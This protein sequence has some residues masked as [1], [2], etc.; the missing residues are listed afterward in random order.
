MEDDFDQ[1]SYRIAHV[2]VQHGNQHES[3]GGDLNVDGSARSQLGGHQAKDCPG[4][5]NQRPFRG[6]IPLSKGDIL[7]PPR[8]V[9]T[10]AASGT[11]NS[12]SG[13][14]SR[15]TE[16]GFELVKPSKKGSSGGNAHQ[17]LPRTSNPFAQLAEME[18]SEEEGEIRGYGSKSQLGGISSPREVRAKDEVTPV[19][20]SGGESPKSPKIQDSQEQDEIAE[21]EEEEPMTPKA[22]RH[23]KGRN[24]EDVNHTPDRGNAAK[25]RVRSEAKPEYQ[26][27]ATFSQL[28]P[29]NSEDPLEERRPD[30]L[31][32]PLNKK[33]EPPEQQEDGTTTEDRAGEIRHEQASRPPPEPGEAA[34]NG[35]ELEES[36]LREDPSEENKNLFDEAL[37]LARKREQI[38][39]RICR[40]RSRIR[41][42]NEGDSPSK[43]FF[44]SFKAKQAYETISAIRLETG[45][46]L[47]DER[48]I[49]EHVEDTYK[50]LYTAEPEREEFNRK[51]EEA[52]TL[53][54]KKLTLAQNVALGEMP[55]DEL[56]EEVVQSLPSDRAPG[57]DGVTAKILVAC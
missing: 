49:L 34:T 23:T 32:L 39:T 51:R 17:D 27:V 10:G 54:D 4:Q 53:I 38:D 45:E 13:S 50:E 21:A 3:Q 11:K 30:R 57:L 14:V 36:R 33:E 40:I 5:Q 46:M 20:S 1:A 2:E 48:K 56:I 42:L 22:S 31:V 6:F 8:K 12:G 25:R 29:V 43:F 26:K 16:E 18:G 52:M 55:T 47:T 15:Y 37:Q 19:A 7:L 41:W 28:L 44:A 35:Q 9:T 24:P